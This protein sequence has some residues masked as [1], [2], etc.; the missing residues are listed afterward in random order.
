[1][2][3]WVGR[4][5][6]MC[7]NVCVYVRRPAGRQT[8]GVWGGRITI[9][10]VLLHASRQIDEHVSLARRHANRVATCCVVRGSVGEN[11]FFPFVETCAV[12]AEKQQL[13]AHGDAEFGPM[14][15]LCVLCVCART[16]VC[17]CVCVRVCA[18][19]C[20]CVCVCV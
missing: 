8:K 10:H 14:C 4:Y 20:V 6:Y 15:V 16:H 12:P 13:V 3:D 5:M 18:C 11:D 19:V 7:L 9:E 1:M 2:T 17:V